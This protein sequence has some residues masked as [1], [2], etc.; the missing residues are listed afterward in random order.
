MSDFI[1]GVGLVFVVEGLLW[2][3][4]PSLAISMLEMARE[5]GE[6]NLRLLGA[7]SVMLGVLVVW[8]VRG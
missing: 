5:A 3:L 2:A 4:F 7:L 1:V 8:A 6:T